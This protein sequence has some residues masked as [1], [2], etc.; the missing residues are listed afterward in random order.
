MS[1]LRGPGILPA[2][3]P[4]PCLVTHTV[5]EQTS[6]LPD[7]PRLS[8]SSNILPVQRMR[9][10]VWDSSARVADALLKIAE[11]LPQYQVSSHQ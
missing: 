5:T 6:A 4:S 2:S 11:V 8:C 9:N 3:L 7:A 1:E 10:S